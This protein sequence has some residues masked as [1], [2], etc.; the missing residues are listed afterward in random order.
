MPA[1]EQT[2]YNQKLLHVVFGLTSVLLLISTVWMFAADEKR[3]WKGYQRQF[4]SA[5]E[6]LTQWR[7]A[8]VQSATYEEQLAGLNAK[9]LAARS[10][11]PDPALYQAFKSE[12]E[13]DAGRLGIAPYS[14]DKLD[15]TFAELNEFSGKIAESGQSITAALAEENTA[16]A[17]L[18]E[19]KAALAALVDPDRATRKAAEKMVAAAEEA[20]ETASEAVTTARQATDAISDDMVSLRDAKFLSPLKGLLK[21]SKDREIELS[22]QRKF[23][24]ADNDAAKAQLGLAVRDGRTQAEMDEI[25]GRIDAINN[26]EGGLKDLSLQRQE[27]TAHRKRLQDILGLMQVDEVAVDAEI[28]ALTESKVRLETSLVEKEVAYFTSRPPFIGKKWLELPILNAFNS[29][30]KIDNLWTDNLTLANGSF[31][32]VRRF[33]RCTTCHKGI[34]KTSPGTADKPLYLEEQIVRFAIQ[35]PTDEPANEDGSKPGLRSIYGF[36]VA[37]HGLIDGNDAAVNLVDAQSLAATARIVEAHSGDVVVGLQV[38][39]V[40]EYV[41]NDKVLS[42][43]DVEQFLIDGVDWGEE[44]TLTIRRGMPHPFTSHPRLDLFVGSLSPHSLATFGCTSCHE[45]QGSATAFGFA[46]HT[47]NDPKQA[48]QWS[49]ELGW[50]NNH[51]WIFPMYPKRFAESSCLK[52]HHDV[53]ELVQTC[54]WSPIILLQRERSKPI[55][56]SPILTPELKLSLLR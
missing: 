3:E 2:W 9:L 23:K 48:E 32:Q 55:L 50:F 24:S 17:S 8:E 34:D 29:P 16:K 18:G 22:R 30:L 39:D 51:H 28:A 6:R 44:V 19:A 12:V 52:C 40:V 4:R 13:A 35:T 26:D 14:F 49:S 47:P 41:G 7:I 20:V 46:S 5:E 36:S 21:R 45:G 53:T 38:G 31:G 25:Q 43:G 54:D 11:A 42:P 27:A 10:E 33:D 37:G 56:G 1:T 15:A